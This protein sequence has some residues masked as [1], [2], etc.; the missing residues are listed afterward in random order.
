[1]HTARP[2]TVGYY[3]QVLL[4]FQQYLPISKGHS[5]CPVWAI[6]RWFTAAKSTPI[7]PIGW[8][9]G[10]AFNRSCLGSAA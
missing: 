4:A 9:S 10:S 7:M 3:A 1:M 6:D 5:T 2:E 8:P